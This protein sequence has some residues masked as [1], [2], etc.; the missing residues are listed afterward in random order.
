MSKLRIPNSL[1]FL[2]FFSLNFEVWDPL[3]TGGFFSVSKLF[4]FLYAISILPNLSHFL[5]TPKSLQVYTKLLF[6]F[7]GYLTIINLVNIN[8]YD[9]SFLNFSILQN[10]V[11]FFLLINHERLQPGIIEK[12]FFGFLLGS[13][14]LA[15]CYY[16]NLGLEVN[17]E[18]RISLF[19]DNENVIGFRMVVSTLFLI[20]FLTKKN[21]KI[22]P[23]YK[24]LLLLSFFP[25]FNLVI[26]S[27]SRLSFITLILSLVLTSILYKSRYSIFKFLIL[28]FGILTS[29]LAINI[30]LKS[31]VLGERL[32]RSAGSNDLSGRDEIWR[33]I[34]PLIEEN[35]IFGVGS[36][37]Y[38]EFSMK[39]I[40]EYISPH[41]VFIEVLAISGIIGFI[42]F[43][44]FI[45]LCFKSSY[46]YQKRYN[47]FM[48]FIFV[49]PI[50]GILFSAQ[51]LVFKLGWVIFAYCATRSLYIYKS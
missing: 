48:P 14:S 3:S 18:G 7:F 5:A 2:F 19:G 29:F 36:T 26:Y 17:L 16:L 33:R 11:L 32:I 49:I 35:L 8:V 41:N 47:E 4:G 24:V 20:H 28:T 42:L 13:L 27:G 43:F 38:F 22:K 30:A 51:I 39:T 31:E 9:S 10:I 12:S 6:V 23:I 37:G 1:L 21:L 44:Y 46:L 45:F 15:A 25:L 34:I 40:S 50:L